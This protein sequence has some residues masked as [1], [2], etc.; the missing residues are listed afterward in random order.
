MDSVAESTSP[1]A[2]AVTFLLFAV[3]LFAGNIYAEISNALLFYRTIFTIWMTIVL[4]I[5]AS[6]LYLAGRENHWFRW[7]WTFAF[8]AFLVHFYFAV[9]ENHHFSIASVYAK[10]GWFTASYN[11]FITVAWIVFTVMLWRN[12]RQYVLFKHAFVLLLL[13]GMLV[14]SIGLKDGIVSGLG[15]LLI[16]AIIAG[17]MMRFRKDRSA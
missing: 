8:V 15:G 16:V 10:Q 12:P 4:L 6:F 2:F 11:F 9:G 13:A 14:A 5:P 7:L 3:M 17:I 1:R